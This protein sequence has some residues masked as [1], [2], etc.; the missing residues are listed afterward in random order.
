MKHSS[1]KWALGTIFAAIAG[2]TAGILTAP[3]SGK[4]TRKDIKEATLNS[5]T[6]AEKQLKNLHTQLTELINETHGKFEVVGDKAKKQ[7]DEALAKAKRAKDKARE[8][9]SAVHE[10]DA[11][12]QDLQKAIKEA[13]E[14]VDH[15]KT[16]L[17]K[18]DSKN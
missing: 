4:E 8:L 14:V 13:S 11:G 18:P 15:L 10:G 7:L 5:I 9:L 16:F 6:E 3:K 12:D 17:E 1:K 2:F